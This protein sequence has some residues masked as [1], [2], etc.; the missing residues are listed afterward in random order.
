MEKVNVQLRRWERDKSSRQ[1]NWIDCGENLHGTREIHTKKKK[2]EDLEKRTACLRRHLQIQYILYIYKKW[3]EKKLSKKL[4][5][6]TILLILKK[7]R[8]EEKK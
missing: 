8:E 6:F 3:K 7:M 4:D 5:K 1:T 2:N